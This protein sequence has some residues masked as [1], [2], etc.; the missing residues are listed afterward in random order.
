MRAY[1]DDHD[2]ALEALPAGNLGIHTAG[3]PQIALADQDKVLRFAGASKK[4][5]KGQDHLVVLANLPHGRVTPLVVANS[6]PAGPF[7]PAADVA[8]LIA[9][10]KSGDLIQ[11]SWDTAGSVN[12]LS[13]ITRYSPKPGEL[14]PNGYIFMKADSKDPSSNLT[15]V[16]NKLGDITNATAP[17]GRTPRA[18][19]T[20]TR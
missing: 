19:C 12:T 11:A 8:Q 20:A 1:G 15:V 6:D 16:L 7:A 5:I 18:T 9:S 17:P 14:T 3:I 10:L 13:A 4:Q 2:R